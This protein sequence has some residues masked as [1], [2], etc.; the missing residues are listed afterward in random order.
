MS[1]K[2]ESPAVDTQAVDTQG[3]NY[4][5]SPRRRVVTVYAPL[6]VFLFVL[7]FPFYWMAM[8]ACK[9]NAELLAREGNPFWIKSPTLT[10]FHHLFFETDYPAW[11]WNTMLVAV[12]STFVSLAA[13]TFAAYAIERL[14]FRGA[15][16]LGSLIFVTYL[17]PQTLL[18]LPLADTC[19]L[20]TIL[21]SPDPTIHELLAIHFVESGWP[22]VGRADLAAPSTRWVPWTRGHG[23][24][25]MS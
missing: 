12:V 17:V 15:N 19:A 3:M 18:F 10:H 21:S 24:E 14:R 7:L 16:A 13:A 2:T 25:G 22:G 8:T 23:Q 4:L 5:V 6:A 1:A 11:L 20:S 9:P